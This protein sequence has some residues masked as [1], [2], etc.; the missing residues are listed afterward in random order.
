MV[1]TMLTR[2]FSLVEL[3]IVLVILGLL[4]GGILA[5][6]SLIKAAEMRSVS[7]DYNR[8]TAALN[9]F[10][11]KYFAIPGDMVN[12]TKFWGD[13]NTNCPTPDTN[14]TPGTC[15]GNSN[16]QIDYADGGSEDVRSWQQLALAGLIEGGYTGLGVPAPGTTIPRSKLGEA[17]FALHWATSMGFPNTDATSANRLVF[18][19]AYTVFAGHVVTQ[20][21]ALSPQDA[22][23]IDTKLD[24]GLPMGGKITS[25]TGNGATASC[26]NGG[27][28]TYNLQYSSLECFLA[29]RVQ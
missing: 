4:T 11:D 26:Q 6:Q 25:G 17:A 16:G 21:A 15:N 22:W 9:G 28:Q 23:N 7:T 19:R 27:T 29:M 14:G 12:A 18:G 2:G 5:G 1:N 3:S 20:G 13:D 8:Y 24:D 10:R